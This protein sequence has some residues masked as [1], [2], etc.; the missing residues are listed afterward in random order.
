MSQ[1]EFIASV[2]TPACGGCHSGADPKAK[3]D[4]VK[5]WPSLA[6][7]QKDVVLERLFTRDPDKHMPRTADGKSGR[8]TADQLRQFVTH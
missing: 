2:V 1:A 5:A 7:E 4:I 3:F 6:P 8:L